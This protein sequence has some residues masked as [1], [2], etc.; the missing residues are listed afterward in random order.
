MGYMIGVDVGGTFTDFSVFHQDTGELFHYK[1]SST[2]ADPSRAIMNGILAILE[3]EHTSARSVQYLA[4]GTTVGTNALI[5]RKGAKVGL[6]TTEGFKDLMEIGNQK[7]PSLYNL[8]AQKP[9]PLIPAGCNQTVKERIRYDGQVHT[10]LD[11]QGARR[12]IRELKRMGV[13]AVA[14]CTLFSFINPGHEKRIRELIQEEF[15]QA[16][17]TLS[18]ELT[19]EFREYSRM[20]TTV[21]NSYL[22]PVMK[23]YVSNFQNSLHELGVTAEPYI[24]QSNGAII[25]IRETIDCPIKCAVSGPSAGVVAATYI[26]RQCG[27]DKIITFDMGGTS[28]DISLIEHYTPSVTNE[29]VVEGYPARI[30]MINIVTIGAGGGSVARIDNGGALKVGPESAG[31]VPGP[32]CYGRSGTRP[33]VTDANIVLGKLNQRRILGGR[34][35]VHLDRAV[36]AI[37]AHVCKEAGLPLEEAANGIITVVNS[38]MVRAIRSVSVEKGY[39]AREFTLMA[40]GGAGPLHACEV[41]QELGIERVLIPPNPG[42]LCSLGLLLADIKFDMSRTLIL[43]AQAENLERVNG[44]FAEMERQGTAALEREGVPVQ[45]RSFEYKI[46]MRYQRQNFE[47]SVPVPAGK[48]TPELLEKALTDFHQEHQRAYGYCNEQ[49]AVQLVSYRVSAVGQIEKPGMSPRPLCGEP[50]AGEPSEIRQV[51]F[52]RGE[53]RVPTPVY[54]RG[55]LRPGQRV[56]GPC[57]LEQ[58]DTTTVIPPEWSARADG[59]GNLVLDYRKEGQQ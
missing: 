48:L 17:V 32:A 8:K 51:M 41:A 15:P 5:E 57:I 50:F 56:E 6:I 22:G 18:S 38:N 1:D 33:T 25:S 47:I 43:P 40:F 53:G 55:A 9:A 14:V 19:P 10:P 20:S 21:L 2:P 46:D 52:Q 12:A 28:A 24:T 26:G 42:T 3:Q 7:R 45:N 58:M 37:E 4:H 11:E 54:E 29:R 31:A 35:E 39:D 34:M 13:Q 49:A 27:A 16:Y 44:Q 30:P 59:Y 36:Q 23:R